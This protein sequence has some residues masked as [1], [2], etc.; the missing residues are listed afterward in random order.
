MDRV[1]NCGIVSQR[2]AV[3]LITA[4]FAV[5]LSAQ[6]KPATGAR[7]RHYFDANYNFC[8]DYPA[9]WQTWEPFDR[10]AVA[11]LPPGVQGYPSTEITVGGRVNQPSETDETRGETLQE[12][13]DSGVKSLAKYGKASSISVVEQKQTSLAGYPALATKYEYTEGGQ[14]WHVQEIVFI[15]RSQAVFELALTCHPEEV[16]K[17]TPVF[18]AIV[19]SF[20]I[21]C[22]PKLPERP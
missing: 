7:S 22:D 9:N 5:G 13:W 8:V 21:Q 11:L 17:L 4:M 10:N 15:T 6:S 12:I 14:R 3:V 2:S 20:K 19:R 16:Q 1:I 18:D